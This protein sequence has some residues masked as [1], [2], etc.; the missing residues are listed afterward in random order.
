MLGKLSSYVT[1]VSIFLVAVAFIAGMVGCDGDG[2]T[3]PSQNLE[4]WDW[5]DLDDVRNN[6]A[7]NHTLMNDLNSAT[8]GYQELAGPTANGGTGWRPIG[9]GSIRNGLVTGVFTGTFDGQ[10]Y[11]IRNLFINDPHKLGAGLFGCIGEGGVINN[12]GVVN[13]TVTF[14]ECV[15][16]LAGMNMG[17]VSNCWA[18]GSVTGD[19][20]V[21]GL[22]AE[23]YKG[24]LS[25]CYSSVSVTCASNVGGL[26]GVNWDGTV[27]NSYYNYDEVLINGENIITV[28]ALFDED[29]EDWLANDKSLDVSERLSQENGYYLV[30]NVSDFKQLLAFGQNATLKF[31]LKSDLDL[32][33]EPNFYIPYLAGEFDGNGHKISNL[34]FSFGSVSG[35]GLFGYLAP[36][37]KVSGL[38]IENVHIFTVEYVGGLVGLSEGD[39]SNSYSTGS[40][41]GGG[42]VGGLVGASTGTVTNSYS[43]CDVTGFSLVGGLVGENVYGI[44]SKCYSIG[45]VTGNED[46]G[47]L[48]GDIMGT[49]SN[50]FWDI[51]TSGQAT[52]DGGRGTGKTTAEMRSIATF[53]GAG[54][55]ITAVAPGWTNPA[56]M[57]NIVNGVTYPF[58]SWQA[59]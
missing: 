50:S 46:A 40:V 23:N 11:E 4:I 51:E 49:V 9:P 48:V 59:V 18:T 30:S 45:T 54:W 13:V 12:L 27:T 16:G 44:V 42:D 28:G 24:T 5:C 17:R 15:G 14:H 41:S 56:Y 34:S 3:P 36:G 35:V 39:V 57:W 53:S 2:Y 1:R 37:A 47:G 43:T 7:G 21:G 33:D 22:V 55:N 29:F 52:S 58:L 6:L 32:S 38:G 20:H 10:G 26:V 25:N 8:P 31:R 19:Y